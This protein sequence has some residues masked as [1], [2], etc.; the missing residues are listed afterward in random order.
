MKPCN[1]LVPTP[2]GKELQCWAEHGTKH[3]S[4]RF[5]AATWEVPIFSLVLKLLQVGN[6]HSLVPSVNP[7]VI[8]IDGYWL[9]STALIFA[10]QNPC[11]FS[12][13]AEQSLFQRSGCLLVLSAHLFNSAL[14]FGLGQRH[15][16]FE[17]HVHVSPP[18]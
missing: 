3:S 12:L 18:R 11:S 15:I 8:S 16:T 5:K 6:G 9:C 17:M 13:L 1:P 10:K 14:T 2:F 4:F 7:L